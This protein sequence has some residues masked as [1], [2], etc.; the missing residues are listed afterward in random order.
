MTVQKTPAPRELGMN[1]NPEA[2]K[3]HQPVQRVSEQGGKKQAIL[4]ITKPTHKASNTIPVPI[5]S[6]TLNHKII[7]LTLSLFA[8]PLFGAA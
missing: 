7:A 1:K 4:Q 5:A 2:G 6:N 8:H 3:Y